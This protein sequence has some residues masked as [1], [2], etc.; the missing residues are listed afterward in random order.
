MTPTSLVTGAAGFIGS[1]VVRHLLDLNHQVVILDD[2]SGGNRANLHAP[3]L[4]YEG[5]ILDVELVNS[6][7]E[8]H[9][10]TYVYHLAA[11]AA[12]GLSPFIR[13]FNYQN[14][15]I[16]SVNLINAAVNHGVKCFVFTSSL[17]VYGTNELPLKETQ[18][19]QPADPYGIAKY[20]VE[21]DLIQAQKMF[22]MDYIIFRPHNVYGS[23]Q[24]IAD[25]YRNVV[26]IFMNQMLSNKPLTLFGDGKQTRAFTHIDDVAPYIADSVNVKAA[27]N[28]IF[29]IGSDQVCSVKDLA[30]AVMAT[31]ER[32]IDA[33]IVH[34]EPREEVLHAYASHDKFTTIFQPQKNVDLQEGL[35]EMATW[36]K[37]QKLEKEKSFENIEILKK[38]PPSWK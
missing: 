36:V 19:P 34:L 2:L 11:Y 26:G 22:G 8:K 4:F 10:F 6:L 18:S 31:F 20:A 13:R 32:N 3:A 37:K 21:L 9:Q 15:L 23:C 1:H 17:A 24:N 14:N 38:L 5:S 12:E 27:R 30:L 16:G 35:V 29:N 28:E 7:F 25:K 33:D